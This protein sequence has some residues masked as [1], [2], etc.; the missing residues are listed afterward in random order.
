MD[1]PWMI[2]VR[3]KSGYTRGRGRS[4]P[5]A[6]GSSYGSS[7]S[8]HPIIHRGG[9]SLVNLKSSSK[10]VSSIHL[11]DIPENNPLYVQLQE[12][13]SQ[14][15]NEKSDTFA[16]IAK[17][18][19]DYIKSYEKVAKKEIIFLLENAKIQR[20]EEPWKIFQR[21][22]INGLYFPGESYK[23]RSCYETILSSTGSVDFQHFSGYNT[24][25]NVYNF[26]KMIIKQ[27]ISIEDWGISSI[28]ER[29]IS[30]NKVPTNFTYWDYINAFSKVL[31]YN[32][33]RHKHI[34]F[35]K[36]CGKIFSK[37]IPNW[38]LNWW[39]YHGPMVKILPEPFLKLYREWIKISPNLNK[40]YHTDHIC[41]LEQIEQI[42]YFI[43]FS[44]PWIHKWTPEVGFTDEQIP[45]LYRTYYNNFWDKIM[46]KD[47]KTK[48]LYGQE[49]LDVISQT[50]S[51]YSSS[52]DKGIIVDNSVKHMARRILNQE[53]DK[54]ALIN[55]Y[56]EEVRRNLL[57][58]ITRD[59]KSDASM[60]SESSEDTRDNIQE[61]ESTA[62]AMRQ[63]DQEYLQEL[64]NKEK[65]C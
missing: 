32:N 24:S 25:E 50:I 12:Y 62:E 47:P 6:S 51:D 5:G 45:C 9:M 64:K 15:K 60:R 49:L 59:D 3:G 52:P 23:T 7:S 55:N 26:S 57:L 17:E 11:E 29:Q 16:S 13:L 1:P 20:K 44:I 35:I 46:K 34:W 65:E 30:L 31:Y 18:D 54:E 19:L 21:Y 4:S 27:I 28:K 37:P 10:E 39:S 36:V 41:Y 40:L 63:K 2:K 8:N 42:Y 53:G 43:E 48:I 58:N 22:L 33:E 38:F 14:K 61:Y 56:L